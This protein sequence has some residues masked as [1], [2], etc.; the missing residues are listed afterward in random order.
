VSDHWVD[1]RPSITYVLSLL[2]LQ[3]S[4]AN[5]CDILISTPPCFRR[6]MCHSRLI[7]NVDRLAHLVLDEVDILTQKFLSEVCQCNRL[8]AFPV[9][10]TS[11]FF[12]AFDCGLNVMFPVWCKTGV[13]LTFLWS[14]CSCYNTTVFMCTSQ[15]KKTEQSCIVSYIVLMV[16]WKQVP[17]SRTK[18]R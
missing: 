13:I 5:G 1:N 10:C 2:Y 17:L 6:V 12:I 8:S 14:F 4:L 3:D 7:T 16:L 15:N 11:N 18:S 9:W